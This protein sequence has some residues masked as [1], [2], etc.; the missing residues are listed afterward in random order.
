MNQCHSPGMWGIC[1]EI[2]LGLGQPG[3]MLLLEREGV[4]ERFFIATPRKTGPPLGG[5]DTRTPCRVELLG[6]RCQ[7][8]TGHMCCLLP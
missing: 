5:K 6:V 2:P 1:K 3:T 7:S 4:R 8:P